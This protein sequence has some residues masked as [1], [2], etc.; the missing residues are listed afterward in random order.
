MSV[1]GPELIDKR[2]DGAEKAVLKLRLPAELL[3]FKGH[4]PES[5][6]LPGVVQI[7][8]AIRYAREIFPLKGD[9]KGMEALKFQ[10]VLLPGEEPELELEFKP[11]KNSVFFRYL[12]KRGRH[13]SGSVIFG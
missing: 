7:D 3:Y 13:S 5:P 8:W 4:F 1:T 12:S 10:Q 9:F 11:A 2:L 6:I